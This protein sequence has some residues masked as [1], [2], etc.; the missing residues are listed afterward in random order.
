[1]A[2]D[3][4]IFKSILML[5]TVGILLVAIILKL[6]SILGILKVIFSLLAPLIWGIGIAFVVYPMFDF[7]SRNIKKLL[8]FIQK[9]AS[10]SKDK[11]GTPKIPASK[12]KSLISPE[13]AEKLE[14][15]N[16]FRKEQKELKKK[17]SKS[18]SGTEITARVFG[19]VIAY[20][21][22][23]AIVALT[24]LLLVPQLG[25]SITLFASNLNSY[26]G[27][28]QGIL[29]K[30]SETFG[31]SASINTPLESALNTLLTNLSK[32]VSELVPKLLDLTKTLALMISNI[33]IGLIMSIYMVLDKDAIVKKTSQ[34]FKALVPEKTYRTLAKVTNLTSRI[35]SGYI[36]SRFL[37]SLIIGIICYICMV[38]IG[39]DYPLLISV[40]VGITNVIP[41]FGPFMGAI[42]SAFIL[43]MIDPMEAVWFSIF[44]LILQQ[45]DG[46]I[47]GPKIT[48]D[49]IGLPV[50]WTMVA[51]LVGGGLFGLPGMLFGVPAVAV[52]YTLITDEMNNRIKENEKTQKAE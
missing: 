2:V 20:L 6:D 46:N 18:L 35:F 8:E 44:I 27:N 17:D 45:I 3:K 10:E 14:K 47:I 43:F 33:I 31:I 39:F 1:M 28:L 11:K 41:V 22:L 37:D 32:I 12:K 42:P 34:I 38:I 23:I 19:V 16:L 29:D 7:F 52:V 9:K 51:I 48:G 4:K 36:S 49:S 40:V 26:I 21:I 5:V 25:E 50:I 13:M 30:A 24:I 15:I